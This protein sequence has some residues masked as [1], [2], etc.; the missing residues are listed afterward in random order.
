MK[1]IQLHPLSLVAGAVATA[2]LFVL[3]SFQGTNDLSIRGDVR[4]FLNHISM[5]DLP[6][7]QGGF[8]RT[9]RISGIN[10]QV[11]NGMGSTP[12]LNGTGNL[13]VG[14]NEM[15]SPFGDERTGS[16]NIVGGEQN[17]Y[18]SWGGLVVGNGNTLF[19]SFASITGGVF[20]V[21][22]G[23]HSSVTGG[24][25]NIA[26]SFYSSVTGGQFNISS[27][28][29]ASVSGG[30]ARTAPDPEDWVAGSLFEDN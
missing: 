29:A 6:D 9:V 21:A 19:G 3:T 7:G 10:V 14:Y 26:L 4:E 8:N 12:T 2:G 22:T 25:G 16:H 13:I 1:S 20:N 28:N 17:S 5:V 24:F 23:P 27:G 11:V 30:F 15:G 18:C